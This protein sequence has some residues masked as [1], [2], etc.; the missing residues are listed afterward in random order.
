MNYHHH[1]HL[2]PP[3][4]QFD[5][6]SLRSVASV[7]SLASLSSSLFSCARSSST[8]IEEQGYVPR[9]KIC[10]IGEVSSTVEVAAEHFGLPVVRSADGVGFLDDP[11]VLLVV[12]DFTPQS[13]EK[14]GNIKWRVVGSVALIACAD[15]DIPLPIEKRPIFCFSMRNVKTCFT[16]IRD[17][18]L[19]MELMALIRAMGGSV[20]ECPD[21]RVTHII[22]TTTKSKSYHYATVFNVP[23]MSVEWVRECWRCRFDATVHATDDHLML[24]LLP[25]FVDV[26]VAFI[27]FPPDEHADMVEQLTS[28]GGVHVEASD[29][30]CTH[31][32]ADDVSPVVVPSGKRP[33]ARVV[34]AEWFWTSIQRMVRV[35]E[36]EYVVPAERFRH[37]PPRGRSVVRRPAGPMLHVN[38]ENVDPDSSADSPFVLKHPAK[39]PRQHLRRLSL[40]DISSPRNGSPGLDRTLTSEGSPMSPTTPGLF[41]DRTL[42]VSAAASPG[43]SPAA[44]A[45]SATSLLGRRASTSLLPASPA[46]PARRARLSGTPQS[47][48]PR[49]NPRGT[50]HRARRR[51]SPTPRRTPGTP[52]TPGTPR[53]ACSSASTPSGAALASPRRGRVSLSR[54]GYIDSAA[55][56]TISP[57]FGAFLELMHTEENYVG[58]L[59]AIL[60][61]PDLIR[62]Y[63]PFVTSFEDAKEALQETRARNPRFN[64][65]L[66]VCR[67]KPECG[68]QELHELMIRP[69][70]RLASCVLLLREILKHTP[71]KSPDKPQLES[72]LESLSHVLSFIN[73][74]KR[75]M[76]SLCKVFD[77]YNIIE[78]CP[79]DVIASHRS[80]ILECEGVEVSEGG[81]GKQGSVVAFFVFTDV[82]LVCKKKSKVVMMLKGAH[83]PGGALPRR[84][85]KAVD[86]KPYKFL[87][88]LPLSTVRKIVDVADGAGVSNALG[89]VFR[90]KAQVRESCSYFR[91]PDAGAG[92]LAKAQVLERWSVALATH[93]CVADPAKF[94]QRETPQ[95]AGIGASSSGAEALSR[96]ISKAAQMAVKTQVIVTSAFGIGRTLSHANKSPRVTSPPCVM[97]TFNSTSRLETLRDQLDEDEEEDDVDVERPKPASLTANIMKRM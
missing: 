77:V 20:R 47:G 13:L 82:I 96:Q 2:H 94:V 30:R 85:L 39:H 73:E 38:K 21:S 1:L 59:D 97:N 17:V 15:A 74:D 28:Q 7:A 9:T 10:L 45:P 51:S 78:K 41:S 33:E 64:A 4:D 25:P 37:P 36:E 84:V 12:E 27:G 52:Q 18:N 46:P 93:N 29:P 26:F 5:R 80:L 55:A 6:A 75:K 62:D 87:Q 48:S 67:N 86:G 58:I 61:S 40:A 72:A 50:P 44:A 68:R 65:F 69:V 14:I 49:C 71:E 42:V 89:V 53:S 3:D 95:E 34:R 88:M 31:V 60:Q 92:V 22:S 57:R 8:L 43:S 11:S 76:E 70:Q 90:G 23:V 35:A 81:F 83:T 66:K 54:G 79:A 16:G 56:N 32:V 24:F 63:A 19:G 91:L